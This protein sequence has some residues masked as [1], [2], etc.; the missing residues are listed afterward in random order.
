MVLTAALRAFPSIFHGAALRLM[1]KTL[2]LT[3][4]LLLLGSQLKR[5]LGS[6]GASVV[7]RVMGII[8]ATVAVDAVLGGLDAVGVMQV[9]SA[10]GGLS[11]SE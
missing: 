1:G 7:S 4:L 2:I 8:L 11:I 5:I 3:L 10:P 9:E 6:T